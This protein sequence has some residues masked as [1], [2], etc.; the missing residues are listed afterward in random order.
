[1]IENPTLLQTSG[2]SKAETLSKLSPLVSKSR[3]MPLFFFTL[4]E[5][6][7]DSNLIIDKL[8]LQFKD[9]LFLIVRSSSLSE[10][11]D[12]CSMAGYFESQIDVKLN[13]HSIRAA[14]NS[15]LE[16]YG[17]KKSPRDQ[18]LVQ[19]MLKDVSMSGVLFTRDLTNGGPYY[20]INYD[21]TSGKT[22][23]I[24]SGVDSF[25]RTLF[26]H[27]K[28]HQNLSSERFKSLIEAVVEIE[29]IFNSDSLDIEFA[30][31]SENEV[32]IFQ[33]R[34]LAVE[35]RWE[36]GLRGDVDRAIEQVKRFFR[37]ELEFRGE[38]L[39]NRT[40]Y[41]VM[42][43]WNP[44]E[45]IGCQPRKLAM[46]LY[47]Y[48]I[49]DSVW[50]EARAE[51]GYRNLSENPLMINLAG[52]V[53]IDIR[54]SFNSFL[55]ASLPKELGH[56][57]VNYWL[58]KLQEHPEY[59]DKIEFEVITS[60]YPIGHEEKFREEYLK[61]GF[62]NE[63]IE[64]FLDHLLSFSQNVLSRESDVFRN[65]FEAIE[66]LKERQS[67][68]DENLKLK[69]RDLLWCAST[70]LS[71]CRKLG[72][73]PFSV[74]ARCGFISE[75]I[76]RGLL[77]KQVLTNQR[78][79]TF[80]RSIHTITTD[81][82]SDC[83][84]LS[85]QEISKDAFFNKYGHLRPGTYDILSPRYDQRDLDKLS[86]AET[87]V[88]DPFKLTTEEEKKTKELLDSLRINFTPEELFSFMRL[89]IKG[90]EEAKFYFTRNISD[91]LEII[92]KWGDELGLGRE[93]LSHI[94]IRKM[95]RYLREA[96]VTDR[97]EHFFD[98]AQKDKKL[99]GIAKSIKLPHL[100]LRESDI[101]IIPVLISSPNFVTNK[102]IDGKTVVLNNRDVVDLS[103]IEGKIVLIEG[104]DPG[105]DWIF[106]AKILGLITK[107]GGANSH[108][109][110]RCAEL[111]VPAAIGCGEQLF[112]K[113]LNSNFIS[114]E[115][116]HSSIRFF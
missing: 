114:L 44:A 85:K 97:T 93:E 20:V 92:A 3:I 21:D 60:F 116:G 30:I 17:D 75:S 71:D 1:M 98:L 96:P 37:D 38:I 25:S 32:I 102:N 56:K 54:K 103:E 65:Q 39:G 6:K 36:K 77:S 11:L 72:T 16:S 100:I 55:P 109:A 57:L 43:D 41:G 5:W 7:D 22:D 90:R 58:D 115:C 84:L 14:I 27:R 79:E 104:A 66:K 87:D 23:T 62:S 69:G 78:V 26:V 42:P 31:T 108:M 24:T 34:K 28:Y 89:S 101:D 113:S 76:L 52:S 94:S 29:G 74:I 48:L 35:S 80:K 73:L 13:N 59:H 47:Q 67:S 15:V 86:A 68:L 105:Y 106:S 88:S 61:A 4:E 81:F 18:V 51:M 99:Y 64:T 111:G 53:Y 46:S 8:L 82:L 70:K 95:F 107:F 45:M 40:A 83:F 110:I 33:V 2:L 50:A 19:P 9:D 49:T 63:E 10:D 12:N 112:N 91:V